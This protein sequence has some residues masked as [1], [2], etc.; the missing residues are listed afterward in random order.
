MPPCD[1]LYVCSRELMGDCNLAE[2]LCSISDKNVDRLTL[3][4][5]LVQIRRGAVKKPYCLDAPSAPFNFSSL[6]VQNFFR[7]AFCCNVMLQRGRKST[8]QLALRV[9]DGSRPQLQP[10]AS[11]SK[12]E[13]AM[14][15]DLAATAH[16]L[17][18][19]DTQMLA[20]PVQAITLVRKTAR[21]AR[22][23]EAWDRA[24]RAQAMLSTKLRLTPQARTMPRTAARRQQGPLSY[25]DRMRLCR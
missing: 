4:F 16:H 20:S 10:P 7:G 11:L 12:A 1:E 23:I 2:L 9:V 22:R 14:F 5:C 25:Y 17:G 13:R 15:L 24:V 18:P 3:R 6:N 21:D 8:D 19:S